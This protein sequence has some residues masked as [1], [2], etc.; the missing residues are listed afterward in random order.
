LDGQVTLG[1]L[2]DMA[3]KQNRYVQ[4]IEQI[5][6]KHYRLVA[7]DEMTAADLKNCQ[8]RSA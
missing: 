8:K 6:L 3:S 1:N 2:A 4:I 7:P 5:F